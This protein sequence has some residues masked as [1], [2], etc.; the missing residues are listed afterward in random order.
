MRPHRITSP[1][2][3]HITK[4]PSSLQ[5]SD[6]LDAAVIAVAGFAAQDDMELS[7]AQNEVLMVLDQSAPDGWLYARND[8]MQLGLVP[9]TFVQSIMPRSQGLAPSKVVSSNA[10][11]EQ[12][13]AR[14]TDKWRDLL[15]QSVMRSAKE[16]VIA[17]LQNQRAMEAPVE[18]PPAPV[19]CTCNDDRSRLE[20]ELQRERVL[21]MQAQEAASTSTQE[22]D[23]L[24]AEL[25]TAMATQAALEQK[26]SAEAVKCDRLTM[27]TVVLPGGKLLHHSAIQARQEA[28]AAA[29]QRQIRDMV[30]L[31]TRPASLPSAPLPASPPYP[32][33]RGPACIGMRKQAL[34][35]RETWR[36]DAA[37]RDL[38]HDD[39]MVR[40]LPSP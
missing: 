17:Y 27:R 30:T 11:A 34:I 6:I 19:A 22:A 29:L 26:L 14:V 12:L 40:V 31:N 32:D 3:P 38:A 23:T 39:N 37:I 13:S 9:A 21:R 10:E 16:A 7:F 25:R 8:R 18:E 24:R 2:R 36:L 1:R 15:Q 35:Q 28:L 5:E 4:L 33:L 20:Q